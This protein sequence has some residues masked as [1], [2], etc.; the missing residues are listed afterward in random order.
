MAS[1][2]RDLRLLARLWPYARPDRHLFGLALVATPLSMALALL[3]PWLLK[4]A[5]DDYVTPGQLTGLQGVA[6]AYLATVVGGYAI[7]L[8]FTMS[9]A[10][11]GQR[12]ILR[13]REAIFNHLVSLAPSY[14]DRRPAGELL[15][16]A[17]SDVEALGETLSS[18]VITIVLDVLMIVGVLAAMLWLD[19]RLTVVLFAV[20]PP[21]LG[22][23]E[24]SR[25]QLRK[26][27]DRIRQGL[28]R[29]NAY[30]AERVN[31]VEILQLYGHEEASRLRFRELNR[32]YTD[33]AI[34]S[35][36][37]DALMYATVDGVG[38]IC[39][40]LM[41]W[42]GTGDALGGA[43]SAGL[44]VAFLEYL[45]RLFQPLREFSGKV[46]IIQR[47]GVALERIF[48]LLD[49]DEQISPGETLSEAPA[50]RIRFE[51]VRF[52]YSA[53]AD[54]VI[55]G[56]SFH[57]DPGEVVA[58]VGPTGC[59]KTT[60]TRLI[61]RTYEGYRGSLTLD[62]REV[63]GL[64]PASVRTWVASVSQEIQ[65]FPET[66]RFNVGLGN[67]AVGDAELEA[68][69][70]LVNADRFIQELPEGWSHVLRER[71]ANLSVGQGQ[72]LTFAR[73]MAYDPVVV[74]LD[75]ATA[76]VDPVT[77][78]LIQE[79]IARIFERK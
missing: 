5:V 70:T 63:S 77:E 7:N 56:V 58:L 25:R 67:P 68:A 44:M 37:F 54:D 29:I 23:L 48:T 73:T 15:T 40:A 71:G 21:L 1:G 2:S 14:F 27:Y 13:L 66:V 36:V 76:S 41:L 26:Y 39:I 64:D 17:T 42:Y 9:T 51:D 61:A 79:A 52:A 19:W 32:P 59:G 78:G 3:Q 75:E 12:L 18:G 24:V 62:G 60:L 46:A 11:A 20:A 22:V 31:G 69:A 28:S 33:A 53:G 34:R 55:Q 10:Y 72:L 74:I 45:Q 50:G 49:A 35:N 38:S 16:R 4:V 30:L 8:L 57:V 47:A 43:V 6:L 65:L